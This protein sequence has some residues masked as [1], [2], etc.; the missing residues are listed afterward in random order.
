MYIS[1]TEKG[2]RTLWYP[3]RKHFLLGKYITNKMLKKMT[4]PK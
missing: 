2:K 4:V 3:D 1:L